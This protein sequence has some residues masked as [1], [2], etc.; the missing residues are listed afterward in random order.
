MLVL[1]KMKISCLDD[2]L[3]T[4][5][6][7]S[8]RYRKDCKFCIKIYVNYNEAN[9]MIEKHMRKHPDYYLEKEGDPTPIAIPR[10]LQYPGKFKKVRK[11]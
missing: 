3:F 8:T 9:G 4:S 1:Q 7:S 10:N 2:H 5:P 6:K 11:K